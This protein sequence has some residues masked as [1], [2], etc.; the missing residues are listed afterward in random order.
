MFTIDITIGRN[1][2]ARPMNDNAWNAFIE[3][4]QSTLAEH[5]FTVD[6]F[7]GVGEWDGV[8]ES[9]ARI[10]GRIDAAPPRDVI[11][12]IMERVERIGAIHAQDA[13]AVTIGES[14]LIGTGAP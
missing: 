9:N 1:V 4:I 11:N 5:S 10:A 7:H 12:G 2:G 14:T 3:R 8:T 6:T 13:V